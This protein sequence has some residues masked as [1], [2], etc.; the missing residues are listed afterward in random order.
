MA[1]IRLHFQ[2]KRFGKDVSFLTPAGIFEHQCWGGLDRSRL[3]FAYATYVE[4]ES[5]YL[6]VDLIKN[7]RGHQ[8]RIEID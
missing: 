3:I 4:A 2:F 5:M 7:E 8:A 6:N 1:D